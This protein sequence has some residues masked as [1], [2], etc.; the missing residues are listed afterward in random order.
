MSKNESEEIVAVEFVNRDRNIINFVKDEK[1]FGFFHFDPTTL[2]PKV[3]DLLKVKFAPKTKDDKLFKPLSIQ[4]AG[5]NETCEAVKTFKGK[6]KMENKNGFGFVDEVFIYPQLVKKFGFK[7]GDEIEGK[8]IYAF[9]NK[10][11]TWGWK[12]FWVNTAQ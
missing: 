1:K 6:I 12:V 3:G 11:N 8:A 7:H 5:E 4:R 9:D 10:K 2:S